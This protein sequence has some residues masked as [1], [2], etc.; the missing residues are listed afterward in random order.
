MAKGKIIKR[1]DI[2]DGIVTATYDDNTKA[3]LSRSE[4]NALVNYKSSDYIE[5]IKKVFNNIRIVNTDD[6]CVY[7]NGILKYPR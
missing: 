2:V 3:K 4:R 6:F 5:Q 7:K 1:V